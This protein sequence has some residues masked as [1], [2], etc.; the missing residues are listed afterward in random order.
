MLVAN[1]YNVVYRGNDVM[2]S[3]AGEVAPLTYVGDECYLKVLINN[4]TDRRVGRMSRMPAVLGSMLE[5]GE[6][7]KENRASVNDI[8]QD[9]QRF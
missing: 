7:R 1:G 6:R 8:H 2:L 5:P 4:D 3:T 9:T